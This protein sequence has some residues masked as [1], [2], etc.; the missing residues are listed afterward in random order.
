M[1]HLVFSVYDGPAAAYLPPVFASKVGVA[2]RMFET[3]VMDVD[4]QFA[5][6]AE[7]YTLFQLGTFNDEDGS[8]VSFATPEKVI[9]AWEIKSRAKVLEEVSSDE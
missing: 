2:I 9:G 4:H 6:F 7:D 1:I 5:R 3:A 8:L